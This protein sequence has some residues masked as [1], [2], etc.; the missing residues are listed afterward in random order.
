[1]SITH[2][3]AGPLSVLGRWLTELGDGRFPDLRPLRKKDELKGFHA[4]F[5]NSVESLKA[6][7]QTELTAL[8]D[9]LREV[10]AAASGDE[11]RLRNALHSM[12]TRLEG[13]RQ[14]AARTLGVSLDDPPDEHPTY[15]PRKK[16]Q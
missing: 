1:M 16:A 10:Q 4:T 9:A 12:E 15:Q 11:E 5:R 3:V 8:S 7:K 13:W 6:R 14:E 2:R